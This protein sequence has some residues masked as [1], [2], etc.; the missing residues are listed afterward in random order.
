MLT[1]Y[2][3]QTVEK[4]KKYLE[5]YTHTHR[6]KEYQFMVFVYDLQKVLQTK[7]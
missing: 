7:I 6:G 3:L 2:T 5:C 1:C 4:G